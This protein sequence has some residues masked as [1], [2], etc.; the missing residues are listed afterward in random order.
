MRGKNGG[1]LKPIMAMF[2]L[3]LAALA[4]KGIF[5]SPILKD[6]KKTA[7]RPINFLHYTIANK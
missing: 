7:F 5:I 3:I 1:S 4:R 6:L 2:F